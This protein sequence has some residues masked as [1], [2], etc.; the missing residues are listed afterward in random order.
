MASFQ[1]EILMF[2]DVS[3]DV[4][5][6]LL[7]IINGPLCENVAPWSC[8]EP[9]SVLRPIRT[10]LIIPRADLHIFSKAHRYLS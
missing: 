2:L 10:V 9:S 5:N 4:I 7:I 8:T 6:L 3:S 1:S